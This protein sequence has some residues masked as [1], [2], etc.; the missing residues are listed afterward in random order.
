MKRNFDTILLDLEGKPLKDGHPKFKRDK[1]GNPVYDEATSEPVVLTPAKEATLKT[2]AFVSM[3]ASLPGDDTMSGD[4]KLK[5]YAL[6]AKIVPG[7]VVDITADEV[8]L[9]T[10]RIARTYDF[11]TYG[12]AKEILDADMPETDVRI[13]APGAGSVPEAAPALGLG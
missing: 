2:V 1:A 6:A 13:P 8:A 7:G 5:L 11:V 9:L 12:R 3:R 4:D 10:G